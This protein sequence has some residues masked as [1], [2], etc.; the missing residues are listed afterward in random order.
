MV[1]TCMFEFRIGPI[2]DSI[3]PGQYLFIVYIIFMVE[4]FFH[5][6]CVSQ[7]KLSGCD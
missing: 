3:N 7:Y 6:S 4:G 1:H 5:G 2:G